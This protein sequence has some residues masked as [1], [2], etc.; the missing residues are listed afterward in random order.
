[1][2]PKLLA[3]LSLA[4]VCGSL[5]IGGLLAASPLEFLHRGIISLSGGHKTSGSPDVVKGPKIMRN[6]DLYNVPVVEKLGTRDLPE[7]RQHL[8]RLDRETRYMR[9]GS[10]VN[11]DTIR[12]YAD[13]IFDMGSVV[14]GVFQAGKLRAVGELCGLYRSWPLSAELALS[15][16][17][18]WQSQGI[19]NALVSRLVTVAQNR[20]I[21]S[22]SVMFLNDNDKMRRIAAKYLPGVNF[23][24]AQA[25]TTFDPPWPT[26]V[27]IAREII[28]DARVHARKFRLLAT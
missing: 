22:L 15:V 19:G 6:D 25:G 16:E 26:P 27:S 8:L 11:D 18:D 12:N 13:R 3:Q 20:S 10:F 28:E 17:P 2:T 24:S 7:I 1:M 9:F 5:A 14:Y 21:R 23:H 4:P